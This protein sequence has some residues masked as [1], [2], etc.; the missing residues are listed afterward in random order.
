[1]SELLWDC[2]HEEQDRKAE[3]MAVSAHLYV[4]LEAVETATHPVLKM[5]RFGPKEW[6]AAEGAYCRKFYWR[7]S[8]VGVVKMV[9][10]KD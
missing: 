4:H 1:M 10:K 2:R 7:I 3:R 5:K 9:L 8:N 6:Q